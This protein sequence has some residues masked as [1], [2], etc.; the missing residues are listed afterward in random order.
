MQPNEASVFNIS[1]MSFGTLPVNTILTLKKGVQIGGLAH[2]TAK[3]P[4]WPTT[5]RTKANEL[6]NRF[7]LVRLLPRQQQL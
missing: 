3:T 2:N 1:A 6:K 4:F 7:R 5:A